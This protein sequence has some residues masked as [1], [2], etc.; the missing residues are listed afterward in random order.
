[1]DAY[2]A[3]LTTIV[4]FGRVQVDSSKCGGHKRSWRGTMV[5]SFHAESSQS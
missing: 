1:M 2:V 5:V 3:K 4:A